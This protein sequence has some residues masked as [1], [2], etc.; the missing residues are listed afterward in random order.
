MGEIP[1]DVVE[2]MQEL[3]VAVPGLNSRYKLLDKI[4]EGTFSSVYKAEDLTGSVTKSF[5]RHFWVPGERQERRFV[6]LKRIYVTSSPTRIYNELNLLYMLG[7]STRVAPLCDAL[8]HQDQVVA[9]LPWYRHEEF[10]NFHRDLPIKGIKKYLSEL[11]Q[12]LSFVHSKGIIHRDIKPTNFLYNPEIG[13]GVLVDFGL[14]EMENSAVRE[15]KHAKDLRSLE[16]YC[17]CNVNDSVHQQEDLQHHHQPGQSGASKGKPSVVIPSATTPSLVDLTKGYPKY[18]TRRN[19][20]ANRAGTR[21]FRAPEVLMKCSNQS[22]KIDIWSVGVI[23]LSFLARRFPMFQSLD[24]TDSLLELCCVFGTKRMKKCAA[25]HG[26]GFDISGLDGLSAEGHKGGLAGF[27]QELLHAE[28]EAGTFPSYS[29]A[30]ETYEYLVDKSTGDN[31][32]PST[33]HHGM[34][35]VANQNLKKYH[36]EVWSDHYWCFE[37]LDQCLT[38]DPHKRSTADELLSSTFFNE[39]VDSD[40]TEENDDEDDVLIIEK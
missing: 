15:T 33:R 14:A 1:P 30:F 4:G 16:N 10:R 9:V 23:L 40:C 3:A 18:E 28:V 2:E 36:D 31:I 8:R 11:L 7:G 34:E 26:L 24:D 12:A 19:K 25:L 29:I 22:T 35:D 21:G 27:I 37:V 32:A 13:R 20:R 39:L 38:L 6:A 17:P 5:A